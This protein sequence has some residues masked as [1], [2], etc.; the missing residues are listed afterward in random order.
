MNEPLKFDKEKVRTDL[1]PA[2]IVWEV[3]EV[4]TFGAKKYADWN[5]LKGDGQQWWQQWGAALRHI[6]QWVMGEDNDPESGKSH[7]A[8]A[9][10]C[11][12]MLRM[13]Q[14]YKPHM[15]CRKLQ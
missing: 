12:M 8:H 5:Y 1:V 3:A 13:L 15:D 2:E 10:C 9:I 6:W 14:K 7:L 4:F 11:L